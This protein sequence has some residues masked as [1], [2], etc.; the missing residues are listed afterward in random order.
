MN[1]TRNHEVAGSI[2]GLASGLRIWRC[3]ELWCRS[4]TQFGSCIA[5][6]VAQAGSCSSD[7]T[8]SL[9]TSMCCGCGPKKMQKKKK[10]GEVQTHL[11]MG[12][13]ASS[14]ICPPMFTEAQLASPLCHSTPGATNNL[15]FLEHTLGF[16][17]S[18]TTRSPRQSTRP[19]LVCLQHQ[20]SATSSNVTTAIQHSLAL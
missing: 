7:L 16:Q 8:P 10:K 14:T 5:V 15:P 9:G 1:P 19:F 18:M 11:M 3:R 12:G 2:P 13:A 17:T 20:V 4:Q 6:A